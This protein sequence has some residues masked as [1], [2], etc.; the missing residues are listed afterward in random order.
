MGTI[1]CRRALDTPHTNDREKF[2]EE[3][4]A[5]EQQ[6]LLLYDGIFIGPASS[7]GWTTHDILNTKNADLGPLANNVDDAPRF[8]GKSGNQLRIQF[9]DSGGQLDTSRISPNLRQYRNCGYRRGWRWGVR[10]RHADEPAAGGPGAAGI[11]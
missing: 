3:V 5:S 10:P 6:E 2:V 9:P 4:I 8:C 11:R 7:R 1:R